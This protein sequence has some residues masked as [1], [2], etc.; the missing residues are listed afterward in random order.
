M[1]REPEKA[2]PRRAYWAALI[3]A[4]ALLR[5]PRGARLKKRDGA[6]AGACRDVASS[7]AGDGGAARGLR[8]VDPEAAAAQ[9]IGHG[10]IGRCPAV[11]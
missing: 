2:R 5:G 1:T 4:A 9:H 8:S 11:T 6:P 7:P 3:T 10:P